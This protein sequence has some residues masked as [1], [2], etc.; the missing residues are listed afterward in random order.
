MSEPKCVCRR[1]SEP[2]KGSILRSPSPDVCRQTEPI[3]CSSAVDRQVD[4][5]LLKSFTGNSQRKTRPRDRLTLDIPA[6]ANG[7]GK[8][9]DERP[10]VSNMHETAGKYGGP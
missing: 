5:D 10:G 2:L 6:R 1:S 3:D 4:S 8:S 9:H 7:S